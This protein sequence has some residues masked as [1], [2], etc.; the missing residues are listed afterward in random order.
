[1]PTPGTEDSGTDPTP[2][3]QLTDLSVEDAWKGRS[4]SGLNLTLP[5]GTAAHLSAD[6]PA[7]AHLLLRCLA[8]LSWPSRGRYRFNGETLPFTRYER[9]LPV[10]RRIGYLYPMAAMVRNR[11]VEENLDYQ[12]HY[13]SDT[14]LARHQGLKESLVRAF[15]IEEALAFCPELV[16][17]MEQRRAIA[18]R[19]ILK[20]PLLFLA[21]YPEE[22]VGR[23]FF[24]GFIGEIRK[25]L[26]RGGVFI[27]TT[28]YRGFG[29]ELTPL[30]LRLENGTLVKELAP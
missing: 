7:D 4:L 8:T 29:K 6:N 9:L 24:S 30:D 15:G 20:E 10:K 25:I 5:P 23:G 14:D 17:A 13:F 19:D 12:A 22:F 28:N 3:V 26:S 18:V 27:Y 21:E 1:M 16:S 11:T 2:V